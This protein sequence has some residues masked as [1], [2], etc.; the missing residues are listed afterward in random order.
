MKNGNR[1]RTTL[2]IDEDLLRR[3][4]VQAKAGGISVDFLVEHALCNQLYAAGRET[5]ELWLTI[6]GLKVAAEEAGSRP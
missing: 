5:H 6:S 2:R 3:A 1:K 4:E